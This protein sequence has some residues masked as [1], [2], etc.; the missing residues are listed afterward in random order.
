MSKGSLKNFRKTQF[1]FY[2]KK[3]GKVIV[4]TI[5]KRAPFSFDPQS[6]NFWDVI[7][8]EQNRLTKKPSKTSKISFDIP[9][10]LQVNSLVYGE[11][12]Q[13]DSENVIINIGKSD[14]YVDIKEFSGDFEVGNIF[15]VYYDGKTFSYTK[16]KREITKDEMLKATNSKD[17]I[18]FEAKVVDLIHGGYWMDCEGVRCFMPGSLANVT[19]L[20][21]FDS[22]LG[23][24]VKVCAV[25]FEKGNIIVSHRDY[26][27]RF[28]VD[29]S[30][31]YTKGMS[32]EITVTGRNDSGYFV[33]LEPN[34]YGMLP[35]SNVPTGT[36]YE[37]GDNV[38][39]L[40]M[41]HDQRG[42]LILT[43]NVRDILEKGM[44]LTGKVLK[45]KEDFA[46][47]ELMEGVT[48]TIFKDELKYV[49]EGQ[50]I[51]VVIYKIYPTKIF[52][53]VK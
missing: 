42:R 30:S 27:K 29:R 45:F 12:T 5:S 48:G 8:S 34:V 53:K 44:I 7:E 2:H 46:I 47:V 15:P 28:S 20:D 19:R 21:N 51:E 50:F 36:E 4:R 37:N 14:A 35:Y 43:Q 22:L 49:K 26:L 39:V 38:E 25:G 18:V 1:A 13:I 52:L 33:E 31:S 40:V 23:Q 3:T 9:N 6:E 24:T 17:L 10:S 16:A 41:T 11:I 32:V